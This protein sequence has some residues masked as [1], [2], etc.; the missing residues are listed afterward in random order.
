MTVR[1]LSISL[2]SDT[3][4]NIRTEAA[5]AGVSI[6]EWIAEAAEHAA[7]IKDGRRGVAEFEAEH[8]PIPAVARHEAR[9]ILHEAGLGLSE[10]IAS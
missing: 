9:K 1:R 10:A 8:G 5:Q 6:S 2:P 4:H 7:R 3:E